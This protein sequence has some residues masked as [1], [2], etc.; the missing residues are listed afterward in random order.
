MAQAIPGQHPAVVLRSHYRLVR[1]L[2]AVAMIAVV[3]LTATVVIVASD[4]NGVSG[5]SSAQPGHSIDYGGFN[6]TTGRPGSAPLPH[7]TNAA[8]GDYAHGSLPPSGSAK[9]YD[10]NAATGD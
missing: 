10:K 4:G 6:P 8:T 2:F 7:S 1:A 5:T 3:A 9:D